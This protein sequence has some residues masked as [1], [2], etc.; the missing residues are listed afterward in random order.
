MKRILVLCLLC[1][2]LTGC[3]GRVTL[4]SG[5]PL[6]EAIASG[7][8]STAEAVNYVF[9][10]GMS[11]GTPIVG[12]AVMP[13]TKYPS[14]SGTLVKKNSKAIID[15]SSMADG[16]VAIS[17]LGGQREKV[18]VLIKGPSAT[19]YQYNLR[20]D[21]EYEV[22][23]LSDGNG[24]YIICV[25]NHLYGNTYSV[26]LDETICAVLYSEL[27]P[28]VCPNQ[29]VNFIQD[30]EVVRKADELCADC[31]TNLER[32]SAVYSYVTDNVTYDRTL[33][34]SVK[35]GYL[36][37]VDRTLSTGKG[38]CFDYAA[39]MAAMLRSQGVPCKLV[40]GY[41][42][43]AYHAWINV[44]GSDTGW[45]DKVIYMRDDTWLLMDP[46]FASSGNE[47]YTDNADNYTAKY[48]Y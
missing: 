9:A 42:S 44:Y 15:Y 40:I 14:I 39:L 38:I 43:S 35:P 46:T 32:V 48:Q 31:T 30:S 45:V 8:A 18:K 17:W 2:L 7:T 33:A 3:S 4:T 34:N 16:Y 5:T 24:F 22:F 20:S 26:T 27:A 23:P 29:Y 47:R 10:E 21:G 12:A 37:D 25:C 41:T 36:P 11:D 19:T 6:D 28:F 13:E 1:A